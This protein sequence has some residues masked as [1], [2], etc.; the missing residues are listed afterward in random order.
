MHTSVLT[1]PP[2][3]MCPRPAAAREGRP[4]ASASPSRRPPP[5]RRRRVRPRRASTAR[6]ACC[7]DRRKTANACSASRSDRPSVTSCSASRS[8]AKRSCRRTERSEL[9]PRESAIVSTRRGCSS[10]SCAFR[11]KTFATSPRSDGI[12]APN[13]VEPIHSPAAD[14]QRFPG[15]EVAVQVRSETPQR[16][17]TSGTARSVLPSSRI[18]AT[19]RRITSRVSSEWRWRR[20]TSPAGLLIWHVHA[21]VARSY[22]SV[23]TAVTGRL[24]SCP[25][26]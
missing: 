11:A 5:R 21:S 22:Q 2:F 25:P 10:Q 19:V 24:P 12:S 13:I 14:D 17:A 23:P 20:E 7:R 4:E 26:R 16:R 15:R 1:V 9:A 6:R 3:G 18:S 8:L